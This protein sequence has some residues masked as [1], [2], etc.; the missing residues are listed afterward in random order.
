MTNLTC[1]ANN[2]CQQPPEILWLAS[3]HQVVFNIQQRSC[4]IYTDHDKIQIARCPT[5]PSPLRE[6]TSQVRHAS[7]LPP[8]KSIGLPTAERP[9][10]A[11][12]VM[13]TRLKAYLSIPTSETSL[14]VMSEP[15]SP[16]S[17]MH[18]AAVSGER[19]CD[20]GIL[21]AEIWIVGT[22]E[23][24]LSHTYSSVYFLREGR[25]GTAVRKARPAPIWTSETPRSSHRSLLLLL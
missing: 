25:I 18:I 1:A 7:G 24:R 17:A 3:Q 14:P 4:R 11:V 23:Q 5:Y 6:L 2:D 22:I 20:S 19:G 21:D 13:S 9:S 10:P 12:R 8:C 15:K 16:Q